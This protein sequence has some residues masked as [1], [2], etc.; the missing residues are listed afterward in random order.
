MKHMDSSHFI[1]VDETNPEMLQTIRI[2]K[3]LHF[4]IEKLPKPNYHPMKIIKLDRKNFFNT[5]G[6]G[7][8][9]SPNVLKSTKLPQINKSMKVKIFIL[10]QKNLDISEIYDNDRSVVSKLKLSNN[11]SLIKSKPKMDKS[12]LKVN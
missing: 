5:I 3:N 2:P 11:N 9:S 7:V 10:Q 4:L 1:Q 8:D 6:G 12:K